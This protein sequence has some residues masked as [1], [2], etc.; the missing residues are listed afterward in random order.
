MSF[1]RPKAR[2][3]HRRASAALFAIGFGLVVGCGGGSGTATAP[4]GLQVSTTA[5]AV[6]GSTTPALEQPATPSAVPSLTATLA[7]SSATPPA[8]PTAA[9]T[10][11]PAV[12]ATLVAVG[13]VA[14]CDRPDDSDTAAI[15]AAIP[16]TIALLGDN[17]YED[18]SSEQYAACYDPTWGSL[19]D[20]TRPAPGNHD[21]QTEGASGYFEYFGEAAAPPGGWYSYELGGWHVVVLNSECDHVGGCK[22]GSAQEQW[23]KAD[24]AA[25]GASCTAAMWHQPRFSS[26]K[27]GSAET[28]GA[29]WRDLY[30]ADADLVLNGHD[31]DYER[32]APLDPSGD[33]D[34]ARGLREFVVGTGGKSHYGFP[35][36]A[37]E[38][39]EV[40]NDDA[41]GVLILTL[42]ARG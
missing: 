4:P 27:H 37:I 22:A 42:R 35:G 39:S 10:G 21:Y 6:S 38:G 2:Y 17:V 28:Y 12:V 9:P 31:H 13:D 24:L 16:G 26:G 11:E 30:A 40:R 32:F 20:R 33:V 1:C 34:V 18:G 36:E 14:D 8:T 41:L 5:A 25:S 3:S 15:A 23:L 19:K 29:F 7:P